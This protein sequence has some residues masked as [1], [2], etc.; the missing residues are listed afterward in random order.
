MEAGSLNIAQLC[1]IKEARV[2]GRDCFRQDCP[3]QFHG[4]QAWP[5]WGWEEQ[6]AGELISSLNSQTAPR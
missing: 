4:L 5:T 1:G 3:N 6:V 2:G